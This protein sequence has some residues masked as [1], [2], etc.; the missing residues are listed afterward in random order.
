MLRYRQPTPQCIEAGR[1]HE[2]AAR[3]LGGA[4]VIAFEPQPHCIRELKARCGSRRLTVVNAAVGNVSWSQAKDSLLDLIARTAHDN[5]PP[6]H[7][8]SHCHRRSGPCERSNDNRAA[9]RSFRPP[10]KTGSSKRLTF[11]FA[12]ATAENSNS[13]VETF[14]YLS[15]NR[16]YVSHG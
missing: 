2:R 1:L 11:Q 15:R 3:G 16:W 6:L 4:E 13:F 9:H 5:Y 12:L 10:Q 7:N 14:Q 8:S